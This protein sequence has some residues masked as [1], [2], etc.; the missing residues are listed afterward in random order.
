MLAT[1]SLETACSLLDVEHQEVEALIKALTPEQMTRPD[2]IKHG[3]YWGQQWSFKDLL[4]HLTTYETLAVEAYRAWLNGERHWSLDAVETD[5]GAENIHNEGVAS[6]RR[7]SLD[8]MILQWSQQK[9]IL[10][11]TLGNLN[12]SQWA[13]RAPFETTGQEPYDLG[14]MFEALIA[15]VTRRPIYRHLPVHIP[16]YTEYLRQLRMTEAQ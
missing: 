9:D 4:A 6:R 10:M 11:D 15:P 3:L 7:L 14:G 16:D 8:E 2:T 12:D 5:E 13:V 1:V